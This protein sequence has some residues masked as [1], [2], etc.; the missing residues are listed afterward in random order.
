MPVRTDLLPPEL[1]IDSADLLCDSLCN[2]FNHIFQAI[3]TMKAGQREYLYQSPK[4]AIRLMPINIEALHFDLIYR[5]G[6]WFKLCS[7]GAAIKVVNAIKAIHNSVKVCVRSMEK[8]SE[9]FDSLVGVKQ[10]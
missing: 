6:I 10:G 1:C 2:L 3:A 4:R 9:C 8:V 5:N 7:I